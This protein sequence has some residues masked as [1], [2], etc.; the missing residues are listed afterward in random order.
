MW[1]ANNPDKAQGIA[2]QARAGVARERMLAFQM[3]ARTAWYRSLWERREAL[4]AALVE[5]VP[6]LKEA[7]LF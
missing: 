2:D 4:Q 3:R 6:G 5:R 7:V 1:L